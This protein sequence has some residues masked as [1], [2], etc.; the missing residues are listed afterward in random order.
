MRRKSIVF[1]SIFILV[2]ISIYSVG[3]IGSVS[4]MSM[5]PTIKQNDKLIIFRCYNKSNIQRGDIIIF[6]SDGLDVEL[7]NNHISK[8]VIGLPGEVIE[9]RGGKVYIDNEELN[10]PYV[11][12]KSKDD[13]SP[14]YIPEGSLYV[15]GDNRLNS[16]D[17]REFLNHSIPIE[18][19]EGIVKKIF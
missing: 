6:S 1:I 7:G 10:E 2:Y 16:F 8:R 12:N 19:I 9:I 14:F 3:F 18:N 4:S 11:L 5:Y 17:S 15:M 13:V